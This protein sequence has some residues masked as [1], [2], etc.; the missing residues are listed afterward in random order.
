MENKNLF[1]GHKYV[2]EYAKNYYRLPWDERDFMTYYDY[3]KYKEMSDQPDH[4]FWNK[5]VVNFDI[6]H[7]ECRGDPLQQNYKEHQTVHNGDFKKY[8]DQEKNKTVFAIFRNKRDG[9]WVQ[10]DLMIEHFKKK[11]SLFFDLL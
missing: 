10:R 6:I 1:F 5:K 2:P 9:L 8:P 11:F 3:L 4:Y 7:H